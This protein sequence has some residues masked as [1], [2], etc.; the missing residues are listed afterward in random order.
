M[1][2]RSDANFAS[3]KNRKCKCYCCHNKCIPIDGLNTKIGYHLNLTSTV[4]CFQDDL[5]LYLV[6]VCHSEK[7]HL[8]YSQSD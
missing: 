5:L 4:K 2:L 6:A 3:L 7:L 8:K 1:F